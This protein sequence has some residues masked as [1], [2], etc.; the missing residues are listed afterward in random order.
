MVGDRESLTCCR[1]CI[2][3]DKLLL[4]L[5]FQLTRN[6]NLSCLKLNGKKRNN[7]K[8]NWKKT[9]FEV[10]L[11][12][13][14]LI[15]QQI[16]VNHLF[17]Q[18]SLRHDRFVFRVNWKKRNNNK[19]LEKVVSLETDDAKLSY[20]VAHR[21]ILWYE[22]AD[23][24]YFWYISCD[25]WLRDGWNRSHLKE[26]KKRKRKKAKNCKHQSHENVTSA[27]GVSNKIEGC[28][29][30]TIKWLTVIFDRLSG[31][32]SRIPCLVFFRFRGRNFREKISYSHI[33]PGFSIFLL[34]CLMSPMIK[35]ILVVRHLLSLTRFD[36]NL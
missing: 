24:E 6:T 27:V 13:V 25:V 4:F 12:P 2:V 1:S 18:L 22:Q 7:N 32:I 29:H 36:L 14:T 33:H 23:R 10:E 3:Y 11:V 19:T 5:F 28:G 21:L 35:I 9:F 16:T 20:E 8:L 30:F 31:L 34:S 15:Y 26:A 17:F